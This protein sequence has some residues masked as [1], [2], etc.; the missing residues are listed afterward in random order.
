MKKSIKAPTGA[1]Y[2]DEFMEELPRNVYLC[3]GNTGCG[4]TTLA[5][6]SK[7]PT[8]IAAPNITMITSKAEQHDNVIPVF[9]T[10]NKDELLEGLRKSDTPKIMCTYDKLPVIHEIMTNEN[11]DPRKFHLVIDESHRLTLDYKFRNSAVRGVLN[12]FKSFGAYTFVS[13]TPIE[14]EFGLV[15]L[16]DVDITYISWDETH[17]QQYKF[18]V[19]NVEG[20][21]YKRL[22]LVI[23]N[24]IKSGSRA[25][26]YFFINTIYG[27]DR[28]LKNINMVLLD[29]N[30]NIVCRETEINKAHLHGLKISSHIKEIKKINFLTSRSFEGSDIYDE[31][32][33]IYIVSDENKDH[34]LIDVS[35]HVIQIAGRIRNT[36]HKDITHYCNVNKL[37]RNTKANVSYEE[38]YFETQ[39]KL[40]ETKEIMDLWKTTPPHLRH[41]IKTSGYYCHKNEFGELSL[42]ENLIRHDLF[43]YKTIHSYKD[44][45]SEYTNRFLNNSLFHSNDPVKESTI[46]SSTP[47]FSKACTEYYQ[48]KAKHDKDLD[49]LDRI[50]V[51]EH[52][53][54]ILKD[55]T[56]LSIPE[57]A[58]QA[59]R[60]KKSVLSTKINT[61]KAKRRPMDASKEMVRK[62]FKP[63]MKYTRIDIIE[64]LQ[65]IYNKC[66]I[67]IKAKA[68]HIEIYFQCSKTTLSNNTAGYLLLGYK[69]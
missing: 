24:H 9:G 58:V 23:E 56:E 45:S 65:E 35:T 16:E 3:K 49:E 38:L 67:Q 68:T 6:K 37:T 21:I 19:I 28:I 4:A 17:A 30:C 62:R 32:G 5:I 13:A 12:H 47:P 57:S 8:I 10:Y 33:K 39:Q 36:K 46:R 50:D 26:L 15:E 34:T 59:A 25:N 31:N 41:A 27:I 53:H 51:L 44:L 55:I 11:I 61:L 54:P 7:N 66:G 63:K 60:Y 64:G 43:T 48:L 22:S 2:L 20:K 1:K 40:N 69:L 18:N 52:F 14:R 29:T 42:D